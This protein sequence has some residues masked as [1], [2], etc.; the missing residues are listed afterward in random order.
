MIQIHNLKL[1]ERFADAVMSG[2]KN[3]EI[4]IND[5]GFQKG[6]LVQFHV[7]SE[8]SNYDEIAIEH[9]VNDVYFEI[10]YVLTGFVIN[11]DY[12]VFGIRRDETDDAPKNA[13]WVPRW[14]PTSKRLPKT[15]DKVLCCVETPNAHLR[16]VTVGYYNDGWNWTACDNVIAW[17][18]LPGPCEGGDKN[19]QG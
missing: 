11:K 8:D 3:F 19:E 9:P 12:C 16:Y 13:G 7:I 18:P 5:R 6:D 1:V 14:I 2:E 15:N 10:T 17:M 4:R